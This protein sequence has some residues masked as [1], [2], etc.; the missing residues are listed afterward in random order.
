MIPVT[1]VLGT[2]ERWRIV[3]EQRRTLADLLEGLTPA[4]WETPT[5]CGDWRVRDVAAHL[6]LAPRF[7]YGDLVRDMVRARGNMDR[8]IHDTAVREAAKPTEEIVADLRGIVGSRRLAPMTTPREP[9]LD[10]LVH[11]QDI[12]L[13]LGRH[14]EMPPAAARD[15]ADRVWTMRFPPRP[16]PLPRKKLVATDIEWS[17]GEGEEVRAPIAELLMLLTGR[18]RVARA[19]E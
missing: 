5:A 13:P 4:E 9:L 3:D 17:R 14:R 8:L 12:A 18:E 11:G 6:T 2:D 15:A 10:I 19:R 1:V 16:W 7:S